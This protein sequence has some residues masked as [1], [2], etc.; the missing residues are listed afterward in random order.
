MPRL[1][2]PSES[3]PN[4]PST[5]GRRKEKED[6]DKEEED[7]EQKEKE[8]QL[9]KKQNL[10]QWVRKKFKKIFTEVGFGNPVSPRPAPGT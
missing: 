5:G 4:K 7:K 10:H 1:Q 8:E 2:G 6:D 9:R 3:G